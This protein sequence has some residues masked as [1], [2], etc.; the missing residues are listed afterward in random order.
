MSTTE[1]RGGGRESGVAA[2][3]PTDQKPFV[4][5]PAGGRGEEEEAPAAVMM[6]RRE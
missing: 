5:L 1:S 4:V 6:E 3:G 2:R